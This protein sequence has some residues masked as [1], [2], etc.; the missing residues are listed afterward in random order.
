MD[1]VG[2]G[3]YAP[4]PPSEPYVIVSHHTAQAPRK[5][6]LVVIPAN[7][8]LLHDNN[9]LS[10]WPKP[11]GAPMLNSSIVICVPFFH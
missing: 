2:Q 9:R 11:K 4:L 5:V 3:A 8:N 10:V 6:L 1:R 7:K